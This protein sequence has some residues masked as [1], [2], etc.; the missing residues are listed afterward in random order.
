MK[1]LRQGSQG[2]MVEFLQNL[3]IR[4]GFYSGNI[5]GIF[6]TKTKQSVIQMQRNFGLNPDGI[7]GAR[8]WNA[9]KPYYSGA[10]GFIVPTNISYS[11]EILKINLNT[12]KE[13]Y[14]FIE[15]STIGK[16][17]LGNDLPVI[18]IGTGQNEVFY[19]ASFHANEWICSPLLMK[20][21]ADYCYCYQNNLNIYGYNARNLY[22]NSTIYIMPM[23]NPDGVNLVTGEINP[24]SSLYTNTQLIADN[25]PE[26]PFPDGWKANIRGVDLNLQFPAGWEQARQIK[27]SQ[28]FVSPSPRDFVGYGPLTEPESLTVYN[29]T[30]EHN[31]RLVTSFHTQGKVIYWQFQNFLPEDSFYIGTQFANSSGYKLEETPFN[32]SFAG[33]KDWFILFYT[34]PGYTIECGSGE[35]P[36]PI[37]QFDE[38]YSD[39]LG[40]FVL[41]AIL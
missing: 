10:L 26:I 23:V 34:R 5:D 39:I 14:P 24:N 8:T 4:L 36:L 29:F 2:P 35:N 12:L 1:V 40:I 7:V 25:Y 19:S 33:Y 17:V 16:S 18:K 21:L 20:F 15:I 38:I 30:L 31:F 27:Y 3:L 28:G 32:S 13:L 9:L 22:A 37:S 41:G 11:Y 6:G